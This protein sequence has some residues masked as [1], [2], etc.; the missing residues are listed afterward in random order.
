MLL[1]LYTASILMGANGDAQ[2]VLS[3]VSKLR[4]KYEECRASQS[5]I[6]GIDPK[7]LAEVRDK[8]QKLELEVNRKNGVIKSLEQTMLLRDR[9][10]RETTA[11]NKNLIAQLH[12]QQVTKQEREML[13]KALIEAKAEL[14]LAQK[15]LRGGSSSIVKVREELQATKAM[16]AKL[17]SQ[18]SKVKPTE[19]IVTKVVEPTEK[20]KALQSQ[21]NAA[22]TVIAQLRSMPVKSQT[23]PAQVIYKDRIVTQDKVVYKD[24]PVIKEK[25][26]EKIVYKDRPVEKVVIKTAKPSEQVRELTRELA[27]ARAMIAY[28]KKN[29][30][31]VVYKDRIVTQEKIVY[32]DRPVV[33]EKIVE[34]IVYKDRP[35]EKVVTKTVLVAKPIVDENTQ[36]KMDKLA[37]E[38]E[39]AKTLNLKLKSDLSKTPVKQKVVTPLP[40]LPPMAKTMNRTASKT[41]VAPAIKNVTTAAESSPSSSKK[42]SAVY[43][44]A[45]NASIYN[46]PNGRAIDTWEARRS[47]TGSSASNGWI[48]ITGYFVNRVFQ[49]V[50]EGENL[51]VKESDAI[52]R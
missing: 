48:H 16:L 42:S 10:Y 52:R 31:K 18:P 8:N 5:E 25:I 46:A 17:Q 14:A 34:K 21:L 40:A 36:R 37:L 9:S 15:E 28:L 27:N 11:R 19:L 6:K 23:Q 45:S 44:M 7:V 26:V 1:S 32:K 24:R 39:R 3:E 2:S 35:V 29:G 13:K 30:A 33:K 12:T 22:N 47:F 41:L 43:R 49:G 50:G 4:Q 51:W 20:I 38:L